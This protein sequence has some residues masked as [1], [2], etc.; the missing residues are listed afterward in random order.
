MP[1]LHRMKLF[2]DNNL[3]EIMKDYSNI[4]QETFKNMFVHAYSKFKKSE[5][6][7]FFS[8]PKEQSK[9]ATA[10]T[11][12][13][14]LRHAKYAYL[15]L[16]MY[17]SY[18]NELV[19]NQLH[20]YIG[21]GWREKKIGYVISVEKVLLDDMIGSKKYLQELL[22]GSGMLE[23]DD[24][25]RKVEIVTQG[26]GI[27]PAI[28]RN[29]GLDIALKSYFVVVQLHQTHIQIALHQVV[30]LSSREENASTII[31]EDEM[32]HIDHVNDT[33]CKEI[34]NHYRLN[35]GISYCTLHKDTKDDSCN[36][37]SLPNY[38]NTFTKL[39]H[40]VFEIVSIQ[41]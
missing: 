33:L 11:S 16:M 41:I 24:K 26:E 21:N 38:K 40:H 22:A 35:N 19:M 8:K 36:L 37:Y 28:Q 6:K 4:H 3:D 25:Y 13:V 27:L 12:Y 39:K 30:Q 10:D 32:I 29:L 31:V 34:L 2:M 23:K 17:L 15:F 7:E 1:I 9:S 14:I 20:Q 5:M 18:L